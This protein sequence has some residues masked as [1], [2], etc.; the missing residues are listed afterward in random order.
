MVLEALR[1]HAFPEGTGN[2][3]Q[4]W[5][6]STTFVRSD[7]SEILYITYAGQRCVEEIHV[8]RQTPSNTTLES[9]AV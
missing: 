6:G 7:S 3:C 1:L 8:S 2:F 5:I 4:S 9:E